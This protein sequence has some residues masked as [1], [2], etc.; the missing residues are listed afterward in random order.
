MASISE[1]ITKRREEKKP[2]TKYVF[3]IA[4]LMRMHKCDGYFTS[5]CFNWCA[6]LCFTFFNRLYWVE[7]VT[8]GIRCI[9]EKKCVAH[10][11]AYTFRAIQHSAFQNMCV[12]NAFYLFVSG[13]GELWTTHHLIEARTFRSFHTESVQ[14]DATE[15]GTQNQHA[16][17]TENDHHAFINEC[18]CWNTPTK[19]SLAFSPCLHFFI[20]VDWHTVQHYLLQRA[21]AFVYACTVCAVLEPNNKNVPFS[22][23]DRSYKSQDFAEGKQDIKVVAVLFYAVLTVCTYKWHTHN[24]NYQIVHKRTQRIRCVQCIEIF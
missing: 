5:C 14:K 3:K 11:R 24:T 13:I 21:G 23:R 2:I 20:Y 4:A 22:V 1:G 7:L 8:V 18:S 9:A 17:N 19:N 15:S 12:A 6:V 10:V 16:K